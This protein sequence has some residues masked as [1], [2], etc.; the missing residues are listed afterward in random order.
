MIWYRPREMKEHIRR[1]ILSFEMFTST[2]V[3]EL[4]RRQLLE[5]DLIM[6]VAT[7]TVRDSCGK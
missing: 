1:E 4:K 2:V 6:A 7:P 5:Y 3:F